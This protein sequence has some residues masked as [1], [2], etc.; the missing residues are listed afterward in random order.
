MEKR[1]N[2]I[3][4]DD[5][6]LA[7]AGIKGSVANKSD[8]VVLGEAD[9]GIPGIELIREKH[10]DIVLM[11]FHMKQLDGLALIRSI[12]TEC[13]DVKIIVLTGEN[14]PFLFRQM[15]NEGA[16]SVIQ[17]G[18]SET[19]LNAI[20][21][22]SENKSYLQPDLAI[23]ILKAEQKLKILN[24][25]NESEH[26]CFTEIGKGRDVESIANLLKLNST[27][28]RNILVSCRKKLGVKNTEE[29][30]QLYKKFFPA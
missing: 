12:K 22:V 14:D 25:L 3:I 6:E 9:D 17:K 27:T 15:I 20:Y 21:A 1:I 4:I 5:H 24:D 26:A 23:P 29:L 7:R 13:P 8:I 16:D 11:D 28:V 19:V 18:L 30:I 10:P 2:I